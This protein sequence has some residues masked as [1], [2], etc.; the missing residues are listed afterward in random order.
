MALFAVFFP[1]TR[2]GKGRSVFFP[3]FVASLPST[4]PKTSTQPTPPHGLPPWWKGQRRQALRAALGW[5]YRGR[6]S[7]PTPLPWLDRGGVAPSPPALINTPS[8]GGERGTKKRGKIIKKKRKKKGG[9]KKTRRGKTKDMKKIEG[10]GEKKEEN[11]EDEKKQR[12]ET[13]EEERNKNEKLEKKQE[14]QGQKKKN[15]K[16]KKRRSLC[17]YIKKEKGIAAAAIIFSPQPP[18]TTVVLPLAPP[19]PPAS[20]P[21]Q[22]TL[23]SSS[24]F[25]FLVFLLHYF[26]SEQWTV[27]YNSLSSVHVACEQWRVSPLFTWPDQFRRRPKWLG[28]AWPSRIKRKEDLLGQHRPNPHFGPML[29]QLFLADLDPISFRPILA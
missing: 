10:K 8:P 21:G 3:S 24:S 16:R 12:I 2:K 11:R 29:A 14:R 18:R 5:L 27:N 20:L 7:H 28:R 17:L 23:S 4:F 26:A 13:R 22:P 25:F 19:A 6:P 15:K 1:W 9:D